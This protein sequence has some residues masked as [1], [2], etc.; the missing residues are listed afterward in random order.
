[1]SFPSVKAF[2]LCSA[3]AMGA[4][5]MQAQQINLS[6]HA[7]A[8]ADSFEVRATSTG[9]TYDELL[10][11]VFTVRWEAVAG[12]VM[13]MGDI[14]IGCPAYLVAPT[15][16][17]QQVGDF[18]YFAFALLGDREL[19]SAGCA[20]TPE[21]MP[22]LGFRIRELAGCRNV[23]LIQNLF[24]AQHN[25]SYFISMGGT[26]V[27]GQ[28]DM[29]VIEGGDCAPCEPPIILDVSTNG[30]IPCDEPM[31][32]YV[33]VIAEGFG[34]NYSW[35]APGGGQPFHYLPAFTI[36][37]PV[38][39]TY[40]VVVS[41]ACGSDVALLGMFHD[42]A[43]LDSCEAPEI[44]GVT[45]NA[46]V[47]AGDTLLLVAEVVENG[48]CAHYAWSGQNVVQV[49]ST[50][51]IAPQSG[52]DYVLTVEN[53]C[54]SASLTI[55]PDPGSACT[56]PPVISS[57]VAD[58]PPCP[59]SPVYFQADVTLNGLCVQH[60]WWGAG[61]Q[62][63]MQPFS[64]FANN[65]SGVYGL[66]VSNACGSD[67]AEVEVDYDTMGTCV[68]PVIDG[69]LVDALCAGDTMTLVADVSVTG[70][71]VSVHWTGAGVIPGD[72]FSA[73][74]PQALEGTYGI[75]VTNAC[76]IASAHVQSPVDPY[77]E[78][79]K[80]VCTAEPVDMNEVYASQMVDGGHWEDGGEITDGVYEPLVDSPTIYWYHIPDQEC[81]VIRLSIVEP[82]QLFNA[83]EDMNL[84][85][86][87]DSPPVNLLDLIGPEVSPEYALTGVGSALTSPL[88][89]GIYVPA[90]N[91]PFVQVAILVT[92][93]G[94][95]DI[96]YW[97]ITQLPVLAWYADADQ[98]GLGDPL[99]SLLSCEPIEGRVPV[100]GDACPQL[101]GTI[102][103][104]CDDGDPTT[105]G[106]TITAECDCLG[107]MGVGEAVAVGAWSLWPNPSPG[108]VQ[109]QG[110]P[111]AGRVQLLVHDAA[112]RE[113]LRAEHVAGA[114]PI[115]LR[116]EGWSRGAYAVRI[117]SERA[118]QVLRLVVE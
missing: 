15:G 46:P 59:P 40:Q 26:D 9:V 106:D 25:L 91:G 63:G 100:A 10:S 23:Q 13:N 99:D 113:V 28:L 82:E 78:L 56:G 51:T 73:I 71:C 92:T 38:I 107:G 39:G 95:S 97:N 42:L 76:G 44:V 110:P 34:L 5:S 84:E 117:V 43:A 67:T 45:T 12:G 75:V 35:T 11:A 49:D 69:L 7:T 27:T 64:A 33:E 66:V 21:G 70:P 77:M 41:N 16:G 54:G 22:V 65:A 80:V 105:N 111:D 90:L 53:A 74:V 96:A 47:C 48:P 57:L 20:I 61:I 103:D 114:G 37:N 94:C 32:A 30:F 83:G 6:L 116:T 29:A 52:G 87:A 1:M 89:D 85:I 14:R 81:P 68:P 18:R 55:V 24:T 79:H 98:D 4:C 62:E 2:L 104:A 93:I 36:A 101:F 58:I 50:T 108:S 60:E 102:G 86:C 88:A 118:A 109:L 72:G 115:T 19:A 31:P 17:V 8:V 3:T 112:G